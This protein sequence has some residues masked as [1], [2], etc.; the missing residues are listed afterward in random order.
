[1]ARGFRL[2]APGV[3]W[4]ASAALLAAG[5]LLA[6]WLPTVVLDWQ[7]D[8]AFDQPWRWWTAAFVH[9]SP[10][11]LLANLAAAAVVGAFGVM[12]RLPAA[13]ALAWLAAWPL[14][15]GLLLLRPALAPAPALAHYGGLSGVLHAGVAVAVVFLLVRGD[16]RQRLI[17]GMVFAG[18]WVKLLLEAPW[19]APLRRSADWDI[20][21]API[22]HT[23]GALAG[24]FCVAVVLVLPAFGAHKAPA[25]TRR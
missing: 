11:H 15:H 19:G 18:L 2:I 22:G 7:P 13:A 9:W 25:S 12:G 1:M 5:S 14:T 24:L 6:W 20:A 17:A 21:L 3:L 16:R 8:H 23:T 4:A 10:Q